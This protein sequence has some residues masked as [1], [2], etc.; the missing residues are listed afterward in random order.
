M[1]DVIR[2][3]LIKHCT[4]YD[5]LSKHPGRTSIAI[6]LPFLWVGSLGCSFYSKYL[7]IATAMYI[8]LHIDHLVATL[9]LQ[10][11]MESHTSKAA[12]LPALLVWV[13]I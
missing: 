1:E 6:A 8:K 2:L 11:S 13:T 7:F 5:C 3:L 4:W 9:L 12:K 10:R